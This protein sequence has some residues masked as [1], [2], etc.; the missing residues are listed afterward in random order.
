MKKIFSLVV[1]FLLSIFSLTGCKK[2]NNV[3]VVVSFYAL[4]ELT[5]NL[6]NGTNIKVD[7]LVKGTTEPHEY[8]PSPSDVSMMYNAK[9]I[10]LNGNGLEEFEGSL[11]KAIK[12]KV[13]YAT[14]KT[15]SKITNDPHE[16]TSPKRLISMLDYIKQNLLEKFSNE[17][18]KINQNYNTYLTSLSLLDKEYSQVIASLSKPLVT[19]HEAFNYLKSD[20][21]LNYVAVSGVSEEEPTA[22]DISRII[23][24]IKENDIKTVYAS[25]F[26]ES[27]T[28]TQIASETNCNVS[29]LY[30]FEMMDSSNISLIDAIKYN[31]NVFKGN[32][33]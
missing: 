8:E 4:N 33:N 16:F 19:S 2:A 31:I 14:D 28:L 7:S 30:T 20:Y 11:D 3:D 24:F 6:T 32:A 13:I 27:K 1:I 18:E 5:T 15:E 21:G 26:E 12:D 22:S 17:T 25:F 29:N 9:L 23:G 10:I